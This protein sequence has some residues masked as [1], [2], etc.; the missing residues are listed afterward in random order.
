MKLSSSPSDGRCSCIPVIGCDLAV[1]CIPSCLLRVCDGRGR[2]LP[3][4]EQIDRPI[5]LGSHVILVRVSHNPQPPCA[6]VWARDFSQA[7]PSLNSSISW[8]LVCSLPPYESTQLLQ[9]WHA[10]PLVKPENG[11]ALSFCLRYNTARQKVP[12]NTSFFQLHST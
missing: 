12:L 2:I 8:Y 9:S 11:F 3:F 7:R 10:I 6:G 5:V 4:E 1:T